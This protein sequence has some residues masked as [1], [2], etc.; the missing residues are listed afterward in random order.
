[1]YPK[2]YAYLR[3]KVIDKRPIILKTGRLSESLGIF[4]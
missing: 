3:L 1:M 2:G 4:I